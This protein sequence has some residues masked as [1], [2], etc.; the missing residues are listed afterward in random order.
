[1]QD[2]MEVMGE[3]LV[4][5]SLEHT[6]H[7]PADTRGMAGQFSTVDADGQKVSHVAAPAPR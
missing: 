5:P 4:R 3:P 6:R 7:I 1:M 2:E